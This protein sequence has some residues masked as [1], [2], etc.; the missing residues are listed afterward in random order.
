M[1]INER[2]VG[3]HLLLGRLGLGGSVSILIDVV[4]AL[5]LR[6]LQ[7]PRGGGGDHRQDAE[8]GQDH[9][10]ELIHRWAGEVEVVEGEGR[11]R[12]LG[13]GERC[14]TAGGVVVV[15]VYSTSWWDL[16]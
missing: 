2:I 14:A 12:R 9:Q 13:R 5:D 6:L 7:L 11:V 4:T 15:R 8:E 10:V 3:Q 16:R 1:A